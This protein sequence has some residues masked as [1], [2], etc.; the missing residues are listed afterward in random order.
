M[1]RYVLRFAGK[2]SPVG[3]DAAASARAVVVREGGRVVDDATNMLLVDAHSAVAE[4]LSRLLP[5]WRVSP[6]V[7]VPVPSVPRP[8]VT[9]ATGAKR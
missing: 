6:E 5:D 9:R 3:G 1:N 8:R 4:T 2:G 7:G